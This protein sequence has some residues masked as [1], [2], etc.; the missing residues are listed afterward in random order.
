LNGAAHVHAIDVDEAAVANTLD[1]ATHNRVSDRVSVEVSDIFPWLPEERY[2]VVVANLPQIPVDPLSQ[3]SSHRPT[4]YWGR[5][6]IDEVIR[7]LGQALAIEGRAFLNLTSLQSRERTLALLDEVDLRCEV[8]AWEVMEMPE[9]YLEHREHLAHIADLSDAYL[10]RHDSQELLVC[11]LL[12]IRHGG[13]AAP[14]A[15]WADTP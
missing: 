3:L 12:D 15:P 6:L 11:Y 13:T 14:S 1:N 2:E 10:L 7:K 5:G 8:V 4:D 9:E